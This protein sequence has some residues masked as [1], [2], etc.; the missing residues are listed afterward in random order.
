[1]NSK[2]EI[3]LAVIAIIMMIIQNIDKNVDR[4][5]RKTNMKNALL[6]NI[7]KLHTTEMGVGRIKKKKE[8]TL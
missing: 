1:M 3:L 7:E 6:E 4:D 2:K 8:W 5:T